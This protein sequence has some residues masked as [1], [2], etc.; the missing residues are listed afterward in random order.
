[1]AM[2]PVFL[3]ACDNIL[4]DFLQTMAALSA[5][6]AAAVNAAGLTAA[7][8]ALPLVL[9]QFDIIAEIKDRSPS[10]GELASVNSDRREQ[11][12]RYASGGAAA[13]SVLTE[14]S[15]FA[16]SLEHLQEVV[17]AVPETPVMCKDFLVDPVQIVVARGAGASGVLL[18]AAMLG[19]DKLG[20][21][22]DCAFEHDMFV[23]LEAFDASDLNRVCAL[24][25]RSVYQ[26]RAERA[27][28]LVGV[29]TRNL[30]TLEVDALRLQKLAP[31]LPRAKCVAESGLHSADD[32]AS[33][34]ANGY[35]LALVGS[36]LMRSSDP[37]TLVADMRSAGNAVLAA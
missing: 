33:A 36:A 4:S 18:I 37:A 28:L 2:R 17:E 24:L 15:R 35:Q 11:A 32:A 8:P 3:N 1:M 25:E 34:A 5:E 27:Q 7:T 10:E 13:I 22:L 14:P 30:R 23:L 29:N 6:R 12:V 16:G 19:D 20:D 9:D 21:M 26:D 31:L